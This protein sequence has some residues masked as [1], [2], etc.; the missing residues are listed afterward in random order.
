M[1]FVPLVITGCD[2]S[3]NNYYN[4]DNETQI[5]T[6]YGSGKL[7]QI[8]EDELNDKIKEVKFAPNS[9]FTEIELFTFSNY[10]NLEKIT[11]P[12][13]VTSIHAICD[14]C[15]NLKEIIIGSGLTDFGNSFFS[16]D[17]IQ[18]IDIS[19]DNLVYEA[20]GN[21]IIE[22]ETSTLIRGCSTSI[23][24]DSV[25]TIGYASFEGINNLTEI[26]I[27]DSVNY[28]KSEAFSN[29]KSLNKISIGKNVKEISEYSFSDCINLSEINYNAINSTYNYKGMYN[30]VF[31]RAGQN[32]NGITLN[33]GKDVVTLPL[34]M[35][36][37]GINNSDNVYANLSAVNFDD[38]CLCDTIP[39]SAFKNCKNLTKIKFSNNIKY[40]EAY[41]FSKCSKLNNLSLPDNLE[42]IEQSAF[43]Y[44]ESLTDI[45]IP[46][47]INSI[48]C[49]TFYR[50]ISLKNV[51]LNKKLTIINSGAF[52]YCNNLEKIFLPLSI[53]IIST[54]EY[55]N[56][57]FYIETFPFY[58]SNK[59]LNIYCEASEP[60]ANWDEGW[61]YYNRYK[62]LNTYYNYTYEKYL[63]ITEK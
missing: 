28:I 4:F 14:N 32:N 6:I 56:E 25:I 46:E 26:A 33:I 30:C 5:L 59:K 52:A 57:E 13:T 48:E 51:T 17:N 8:W 23:I 50:C 1:L 21:C 55:Y 9:N 19:P 31:L 38:S 37:V 45:T 11:I 18:T 61:N 15:E 20:Q 22:K 35:F 54:K 27:P 3:N 58:E 62:K 49:D 7:S 44:C 47:N 36:Y 16:C 40:I 2:K 34:E 60:K 10:K 24:P 29:C 41:A 63:Q 53:N 42:K 43:S 12:D 39:Y